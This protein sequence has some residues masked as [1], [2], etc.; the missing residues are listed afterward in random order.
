MKKFLLVITLIIL[1]S[2]MIVG[3]CI[4]GAFVMYSKASPSISDKAYFDLFIAEIFFKKSDSDYH[5]LHVGESS[6]WCDVDSNL[7]RPMKW[8]VNKEELYSLDSFT[9]RLTNISSERM[10]YVTWGHPFSR[11]RQYTFAEEKKNRYMPFSGF[12]CGTGIHLAPICSREFI[13]S[14]LPN[15][16]LDGPYE[17]RG[18]KKSDPNFEV[19]FRN[20]YGDSLGVAYQQATY[21]SPWNKY[22]SQMVYSE[23]ISLQ[24]DSIFKLLDKKN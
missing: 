1:V 3:S 24:T 16:F 12:G 21:G 14:K 17:N 20:F 18:L 11:I 22:P 9:I 2:P 19:N 5:L 8:E 7:I 23:I 4:Y 10:Y 15:P 6:V 13:E